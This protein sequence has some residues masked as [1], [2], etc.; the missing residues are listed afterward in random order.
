MIIG[1]HL[2]IAGGL[3]AA[4]ELAHSIGG[5]AF[6]F[7]TRNPRGGRQR[8]MPESE[9]AAGRD[10]RERLGIRALVG[11]F[12]YTVNLASPREG[13]YEFARQTLRDDLR[14]GE[15]IGSDV[16]V[17]HPGSHVGEGVDAGIGR[18]IRAVEYALDG[19]TGT[20]RL[21]LETMSGQGTEVGWLPEHHRAIFAGLGWPDRLG[22]CMDACHMFAAGFDLRTAEGVAMM[23]EAWDEA[24]GLDRIGCLHLNDSKVG[25]GTHRD[26]HE[27]LGRGYIGEEGI[28]SILRHPFFGT[29]PICIETPVGDL[30]KYAG[31]IALARALAESPGRP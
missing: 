20:T 2:S 4:C 12:P 17:V 10:A 7:F 19:Y 31:E 28:R 18:I 3:V 15:R 24:V 27:L 16:L 11:H 25:L 14:W 9:I 5:T 21:L 8:E 30:P 26:R 13:P 29:V 23:L 1:A 6:Q 22:I